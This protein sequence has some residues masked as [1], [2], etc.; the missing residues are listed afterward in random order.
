MTVEELISVLSK[1]DRNLPAVIVDEYGNPFQISYLSPCSL[2]E[3]EDE[4]LS[5]EDLKDEENPVK[6][7]AI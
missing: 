3:S 6:V 2:N 7:V 1:Y 4:F 5:S